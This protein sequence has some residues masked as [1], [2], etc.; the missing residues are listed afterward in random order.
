MRIVPGKFTGFLSIDHVVGDVAQEAP[1]DED[2]DNN[3]LTVDN[4]RIHDLR[5]LIDTYNQIEA[6]R[7]YYSFLDVD[8]DRYELEG[9]RRE[10]MLA[11][12]ELATEQLDER[13]LTWMNKSLARNCCSLVQIIFKE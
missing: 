9:E 3:D 11:I 12:R 2:L 8:I 5:P 13:A 4:I 7:P 6:I 10:V 1:V